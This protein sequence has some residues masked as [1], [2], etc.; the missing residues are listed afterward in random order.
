MRPGF[1][2]P[3]AN[4]EAAASNGAPSVPEFERK[5][6]ADYPRAT[7]RR[8]D[9]ADGPRKEGKARRGRP[10]VAFRTFADLLALK[11]PEDD[12]LIS[13]KM[14]GRGSITTLVGPPGTGKSHAFFWLACL[15]AEGRG[16]WFGFDILAPCKVLVVQDENPD[17]R[18]H[19]DALHFYSGILT[20]REAM[21]RLVVTGQPECAMHLSDPQFVGYIL[22]EARRLG[23]D[24]ILFDPWNSCV[25]GDTPRE[26]QPAMKGLR[27]IEA[28][29]ADGNDGRRP[30]IGLLH[31]P[32]KMRDGDGKLTGRELAE[33]ASGTY[34]LGGKNR[35]SLFLMPGSAEMD[36]NRVVMQ[37]TKQNLHRRGVDPDY[38]KRS[39]WRGENGVFSRIPDHE[40]DWEAFAGKSEPVAKIREEHILKLFAFGKRAMTQGAAAKQLQEMTE[41]GRSAAYGALDYQKG[42]FA[43]LIEPDLMAGTLRLSA[44]GLARAAAGDED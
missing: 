26:F 14:L 5:L 25:E 40:F 31:H 41:C 16:Q 18:L 6:T 4:A 42:R 34:Q 8:P 38:P 29:A 21:G 13:H 2:D 23:P 37:V 39:A 28:A 9:P 1:Y 24:A 44:E 11:I 12:Y 19:G 32:R 43:G 15:L 36:D 30:A 7:G 27:E 35:V 10:L 3:L 22:E 33:R 17:E 20:T